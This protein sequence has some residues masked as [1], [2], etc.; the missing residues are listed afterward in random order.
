MFPKIV[1]RLQKMDKNNWKNSVWSFFYDS[2]KFLVLNM[3]YYNLIF[4]SPEN[5]SGVKYLVKIWEI[6]YISHTSFLVWKT[7]I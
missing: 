6:I 4:F 5:R 3:E 7:G 1:S 2:S